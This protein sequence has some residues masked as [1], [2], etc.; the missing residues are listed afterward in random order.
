MFE[1]DLVKFLND[2]RLSLIELDLTN[3]LNYFVCIVFSMLGDIR[4]KET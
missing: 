3:D 1:S 4:I 2:S